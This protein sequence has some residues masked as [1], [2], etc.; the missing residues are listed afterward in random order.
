MHKQRQPK[1]PETIGV[2][3]SVR[4]PGERTA[5][6][7]AKSWNMRYSSFGHFHLALSH[8]RL[9]VAC[10]CCV[11][12]KGMPSDLLVIAHF[13]AAICVACDREHSFIGHCLAAQHRAPI[14]TGAFPP[15]FVPPSGIVTTFHSHLAA[16]FNNFIKKLDAAVPLFPPARAH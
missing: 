8:R 11:S 6:V 7:E 1:W 2:R 13:T 14:E 16:N 3:P 9:I 12:S 10:C 5:C 15:P 4:S